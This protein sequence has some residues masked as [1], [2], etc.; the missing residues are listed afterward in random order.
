MAEAKH[1]GTRVS[2]ADGFIGAIA[3]SRD[4]MVATWDVA[5][6]VSMGVA[7]INPRTV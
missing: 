3:K 6:F 2:M 5:P 1:A 4:L 7:V